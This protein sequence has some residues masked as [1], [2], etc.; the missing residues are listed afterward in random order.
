MEKGFAADTFK[1]AIRSNDIHGLSVSIIVR[2]VTQDALDDL[3]KRKENEN[4]LIEDA[5]NMFNE[6]TF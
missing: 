6:S 4:A 3:E 1:H 2:E 5:I